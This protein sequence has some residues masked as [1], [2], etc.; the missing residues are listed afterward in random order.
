MDLLQ[1]PMPDSTW[2]DKRWRIYGAQPRSCLRTSSAAGA[3]VE[4]SMITEGCEVYGTVEHS[5]LFA[6]VEVERGRQR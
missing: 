6:G 3:T 4:N 1:L 5:V 2:H